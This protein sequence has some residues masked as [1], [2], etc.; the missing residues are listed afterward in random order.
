MECFSLHR[1]A[2]D[3]L[4][5]GHPRGLCLHLTL[6]LS[7]SRT[8]QKALGKGLVIRVL[9][10]NCPE[11]GSLG[12]GC[13]LPHIAADPAAPLGPLLHSRHGQEALVGIVRA[14][15]R[16]VCPQEE[17]SPCGEVTLKRDRSFSEHDLAQLRS[18]VASGL[19]SATQPPGGTEPPRPRAGSARVWRPGARDQGKCCFSPPY[20]PSPP[21]RPILWAPIP[22][23][24][25]TSS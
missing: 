18:E 1:R 20:P 16:L 23:P 15:L 4:V 17:E 21:P 11:A 14:G 22:P 25:P 2:G 8:S 10:M 12:S 9:A 3:G 24:Q 7:I 13:R 19:Q 6:D 5:G